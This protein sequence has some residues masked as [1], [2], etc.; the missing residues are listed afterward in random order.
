MRVIYLLFCY[1]IHI[2]SEYSLYV[3]EIEDEV[4]RPLIEVTLGDGYDEVTP[5][6]YKELN[7]TIYKLFEN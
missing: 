2:N 7:D 3:C 1:F 4:N 5:V 6:T